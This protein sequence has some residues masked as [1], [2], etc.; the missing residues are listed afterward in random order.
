MKGKKIVKW[1]SCLAQVSANLIA[2]L[3]QEITSKEIYNLKKSSFIL[4][5]NLFISGLNWRHGCFRWWWSVWLNPTQNLLTNLSFNFKEMWI[6]FNICK[7]YCQI[8]KLTK[9][10]SNLPDGL[11]KSLLN[12][13]TK[14][15]KIKLIR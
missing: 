14:Y 7:K 5:K 9:K 10:W 2:L 15:L 3:R 1:D 6:I 8:R 4:S 13:S 11:P 12:D